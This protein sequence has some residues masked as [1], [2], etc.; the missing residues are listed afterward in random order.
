MDSIQSEDGPIFLQH[1][2]K[3]KS[4]E[5]VVSK[6]HELMLLI[7]KETAEFLTHLNGRNVGLMQSTRSFWKKSAVLFP[8]LTKAALILYN[9]PASSA[10]IER[11]FSI[12]GITCR[13]NA[14]NMGAKMIISRSMLKANLNLLDFDFD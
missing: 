9:I 4:A 6:T 12:C 10:F 1:S 11:F 3:N 7:R 5:S 8:N 2:Q 14:G 13:K